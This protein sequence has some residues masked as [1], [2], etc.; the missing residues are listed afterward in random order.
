M[1]YKKRLTKPVVLVSFFVLFCLSVWVLSAP[2]VRAQDYVT[3]YNGPI[4]E[5]G[6]DKCPGGDRIS[7]GQCPAST[8][9]NPGT[10]RFGYRLRL[11][12]SSAKPGDQISLLFDVQAEWH[13]HDCDVGPGIPS[14]A[15]TGEDVYDL[16][17]NQHGSNWFLLRGTPNYETTTIAYSIDTGG[18]TNQ[19]IQL[20][21][22]DWS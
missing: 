6:L 13:F 9:W 5:S 1:D 15:E 16:M 7:Y 21:A 14:C 8:L 17:R 3:I 10:I 2:S 20:Q 4:G 22:I 18:I 11:G 12:Q 19:P